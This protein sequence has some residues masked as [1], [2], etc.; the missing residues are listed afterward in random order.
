MFIKSRNELQQ[1]CC[2]SN[3]KYFQKSLAAAIRHGKRELKP[4]QALAYWLC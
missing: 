4:P 2:F 3:F 1:G